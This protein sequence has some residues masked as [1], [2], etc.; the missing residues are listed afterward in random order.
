MVDDLL[1]NLVWEG[2]TVSD[3]NRL[4]YTGSFVVA[5]R[6][7]LIGKKKGKM[8]KVKPWWLRRLERSIE[9]WRKDLGRIE[10]I[11]KGTEAT[12]KIMDYLVRR[13]DLVKERHDDG[14]YLSEE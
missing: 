7:G 4:L 9:E 8:E 11:R 5:D 2:M 10:E 13:Y 1:H 6:L 14:E 12:R 3:I